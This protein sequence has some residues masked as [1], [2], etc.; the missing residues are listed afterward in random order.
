M[1]WYGLDGIIKLAII[2]TIQWFWSVSVNA[3]H[4]QMI[5]F[6]CIPVSIEGYLQQRM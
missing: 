4:M 1:K 2:T 5:S 6:H 3:F